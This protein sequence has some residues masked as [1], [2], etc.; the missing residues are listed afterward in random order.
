LLS[1]SPNPGDVE[2]NACGCAENAEESSV[3]GVLFASEGLK[4]CG[5]VTDG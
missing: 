4:G 3:P 1:R 5:D 2:L